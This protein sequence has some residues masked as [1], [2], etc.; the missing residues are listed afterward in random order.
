M[1]W[2]GAGGN[3][4][5]GTGTYYF[6][7]G[8]LMILGALGEVCIH[9]AYPP[10]YRRGKRANTESVDYWKHLPLRRFRLIR[11]LLARLGG[12]LAAFLQRLWRLL[13]H[14]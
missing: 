4:A 12:H 11:C 8:M 3:G 6:F 9:Q 5:A 10:D 7:G 14:R 2:R 13:N 1:G